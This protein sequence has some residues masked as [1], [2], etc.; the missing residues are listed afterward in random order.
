VKKIALLTLLVG[1]LLATNL[2]AGKPKFNTNTVYMDTVTGKPGQQV[3]VNVYLYNV[4]SLAGCQVPIFFRS[5]K[6]D[7]WCDSISF[8]D[9][10]MKYFE[11]NDVK[12]P[13]DDKEDKVAYF[14]FINT[15]DPKVYVDPLAPGSGLL[16]SLYFTIPKDSPEGVVEL[17]RGMIP[18]PHISFI[19]AVWTQ[20]GEETDG[21]FIESV[22]R[23]KK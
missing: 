20:D 11:F 15:I 5:D 18:H 22:I 1:L 14:S 9:S 2:L 19:F 3:K 16:A 8:V 6:I 17:K 23:V 10:R 13:M 21:E 4:D 7:L 12:L